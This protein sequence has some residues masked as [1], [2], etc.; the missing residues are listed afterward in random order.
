MTRAEGDTMTITVAQV[1]LDKRE[2]EV[3]GQVSAQSGSGAFA[4]SVAI[5][6]NCDG[7]MDAT[8]AVTVDPVLQLG[9]FRYRSPRNAFIAPPSTVCV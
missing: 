2:L 7:N 3:R 8:A 1:R 9:D 5:D 4:P 6:A